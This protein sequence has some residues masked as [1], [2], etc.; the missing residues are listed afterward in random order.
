MNK[1]R[2]LKFVGD[3]MKPKETLGNLSL[4]V[5][6]KPNDSQAHFQMNHVFLRERT[7][8]SENVKL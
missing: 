6:G 2:L 1:L 3:F 7:L 4:V 5:L 8:S